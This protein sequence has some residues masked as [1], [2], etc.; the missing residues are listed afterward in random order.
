MYNYYRFY[1]N[2]LSLFVKNIL[3]LRSNTLYGFNTTRNFLLR[4]TIKIVLYTVYKRV[5]NRF[6]TIV[7]NNDLDIRWFVVTRVAD[8]AGPNEIILITSP[9][10]SNRFKNDAF[11]ASKKQ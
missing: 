10:E 3:Q 6:Q 4:Y 9:K 8:S 5:N 11:S 7:V 1:N 2:S